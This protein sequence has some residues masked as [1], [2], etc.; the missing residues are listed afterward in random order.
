MNISHIFRRTGFLVFVFLLLT[1]AGCARTVPLQNIDQRQVAVPADR[2]GAEMI[3][4]AILAGGASK[5]WQMVEMEPG[6]IVGKVMVRQ[7]MA[8][9]DIN[10]DADSYSIAYK[11]SQ[12][13]LY[14][15]SKI[16]RNYNKWVILL[17]QQ[18]AMNL[19]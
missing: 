8:S 6:H 2:D 14:D 15:G 1:T 10:Y 12:N 7:H 11:D 17:D 19:P 18:I 13:L 9:V 16:H 3:K 5:G 4:A